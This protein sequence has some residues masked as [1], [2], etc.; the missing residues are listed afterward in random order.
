MLWS[1]LRG[2]AAHNQGEPAISNDYAFVG[3]QPG[4]H[5]SSSSNL[6]LGRHSHFDAH[7]IQAS[8]FVD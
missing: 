2:V 6:W 8:Y 7:L 1:P 4:T 3:G 5:K